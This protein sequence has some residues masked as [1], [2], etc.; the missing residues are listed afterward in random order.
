MSPA[1]TSA[2]SASACVSRPH[3]GSSSA[4]TS[5]GPVQPGHRCGLV[6]VEQGAARSAAEA[7]SSAPSAERERGQDRLVRAERGAQ[8]SRR[9]GRLASHRRPT[10]RRPARRPPPCA[11]SSNARPRRPVR[12]EAAASSGAP[13]RTRGTASTPTSSLTASSAPRNAPLVRGAAD[14][15]VEG[16][17]GRVD[18][19]VDTRC[20][21]SAMST[22]PAEPLVPPVADR[23][24]GRTPAA[25]GSRSRG[26]AHAATSMSRLVAVELDAVAL[27][28]IGHLGWRARRRR[29]LPARSA[30]RR[31]AAPRPAPRPRAT[32]RG[33]LRSPARDR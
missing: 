17:A 9:A 2:P 4:R 12:R 23:A 22:A 25:R 10:A 29:G 15:T 31:P 11:R 32:G 3:S 30:G 33:R 20:R 7:A 6:A 1:T 24:P 26:D 13:R 18:R 14:T 28:G 19:G 27:V 5:L 21:S 8:R 16:G